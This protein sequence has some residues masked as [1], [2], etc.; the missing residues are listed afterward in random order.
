M[1]REF[2]WHSLACPWQ[3]GRCPRCIASRMDFG[4]FSDEA[5]A[6]GSA[7]Q[8]PGSATEGH[9]FQGKPWD[10]ISHGYWEYQNHGRVPL[11]QL[12]GDVM[13]T[14]LAKSHQHRKS[15]I[16]TYIHVYSAHAH[17]LLQQCIQYT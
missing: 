12:H 1:L 8:F 6:N 3:L 5:E 16:A 7:T 9:S 13:F 4:D 17:Y 11:P 10:L 14:V 2:T 15:N